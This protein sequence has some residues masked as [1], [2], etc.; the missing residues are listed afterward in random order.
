MIVRVRFKRSFI[1]NRAMSLYVVLC[2]A[3]GTFVEIYFL[4]VVSG[5]ISVL[6]TLSLIMFTFIVGNIIMGLTR[7]SRA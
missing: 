7:R 3:V 2:F 6:N 5:Y 4:K 1:G